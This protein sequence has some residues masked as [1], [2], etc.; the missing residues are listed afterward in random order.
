MKLEEYDGIHL[1]REVEELAKCGIHKGME[2]TILE[3]QKIRGR[4]LVFFPDET[5]ADTIVCRIKEKDLELVC[6]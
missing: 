6:R 5:G 1:N 4:W 2:G 3:P